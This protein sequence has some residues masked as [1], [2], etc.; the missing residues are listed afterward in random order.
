MN[1][2]DILLFR[3]YLK[4]TV[5]KNSIIHIAFQGGEPLL[6][7]LSF[8]V[9]FVSVMKELDS[10]EFHYSLQT[11][12]TLIDKKTAAFFKEEGFLVGISLDGNENDHDRYRHFSQKGSYQRIM[13][14]VRIL[15]EQDVDFNV[16]SVITRDMAKDPGRL[17]DFYV[18]N[19]FAYV[20]LIPC[21]P[22]LGEENKSCSLSPELYAFFATG[23]FEKWRRSYEKGVYIRVNFVEN[24]IASLLGYPAVQ[25]GSNGECRIQSVLEADMDVYP[26]DFYCL[27]EYRLYN[28]K[29]RAS[30]EVT[31]EIEKRFLSE[32]ERPELCLDCPFLDL[33]NGGCR[34]QRACYLTDTKCFR[35][36]ML[37][38]IIPQ[39]QEILHLATENTE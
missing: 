2:A 38:K 29:N 33:C 31:Y 9:F 20:Q 18:E 10:Y 32:N 34:R 37:E 8:Y 36:K 16:L 4:E 24:L 17:F 21:L 30:R 7:P 3:D 5:P 15:R 11:N 28:L 26:C 19:G 6:A 27:D 35:R 1:R 14:T 22:P 13:E 39:L 25:C 23:F 12:G